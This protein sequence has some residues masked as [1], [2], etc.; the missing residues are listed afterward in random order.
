MSSPVWLHAKLT[1]HD[2]PLPSANARMP[3]LWVVHLVWI[4][5]DAGQEDE[6]MLGTAQAGVSDLAGS[7]S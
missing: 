7:A 5:K 1:Y 2:L 3:S 4:K 6:G